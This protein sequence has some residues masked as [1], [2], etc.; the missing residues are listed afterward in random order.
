MFR[1]FVPSLNR[2]EWARKLIIPLYMEGYIETMWNTRKADKRGGWRL[3][4]GLWSP[5]FFNMRPVGS[6]PALFYDICTSMSE[7]IIQSAEVEMLVGVDMAGIPLVGGI[8]RAMYDSGFPVK[9]GYTRPLPR[10]V[11]TPLECLELIREIDGRV[12]DYSD[13]EY[14]EGNLEPMRIGI[15]DD[16]ATDLGSK[17]IARTIVLW[18]AGLRNVQVT[19]DDV[20]Y[21]LN[22]NKHNVQKGVDFAANQEAGLCPTKLN[23][24]YVLEIDDHLAELEKVMKPGEFAVFI[25]YQQESKRYQEDTG[26]EER[27]KAIELAAQGK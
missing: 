14:L 7:L 25:N 19:C 8:A 2:E 17:I 23:V 10:K 18:Q 27:R 13:K 16:M 21:F 4:S 20:F 24:K 3:K 5:W 11:K 15:L 26:E 9:V 1:K 12:T 22:R 6:S